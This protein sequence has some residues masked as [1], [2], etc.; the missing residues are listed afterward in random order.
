MLGFALSNADGAWSVA[1]ANC[2][3]DGD[4]LG[5]AIQFGTAGNVIDLVV[6]ILGD[7]NEPC[8]SRRIWRSRAALVLRSREENAFS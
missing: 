1:F 4:K 3:F 2:F 7:G 6:C 8:N 5:L